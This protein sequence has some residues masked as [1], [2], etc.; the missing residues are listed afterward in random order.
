MEL[1]PLQALRLCLQLPR[2]MAALF[3]PVEAA[4]WLVA[5]ER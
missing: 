1:S 4:I 2:F 3:M 5:Q